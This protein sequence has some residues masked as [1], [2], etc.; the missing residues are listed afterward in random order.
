MDAK[1]TMSQSDG[2]DLLDGILNAI[3]ETHGCNLMDTQV[4]AGVTDT[5]TGETVRGE[6]AGESTRG[7]PSLKVP[8][9]NT[10]AQHSQLDQLTLAITSLTQNFNTLQQQ[11]LAL[12]QN[13][14]NRQD[15]PHTRVRGKVKERAVGRKGERPQSPWPSQRKM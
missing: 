7:Q 6:P 12:Q 14:N 3:E 11:Q 15:P 1:S 10:P 5:S 9:E 8:P 13:M 2:S 4:P